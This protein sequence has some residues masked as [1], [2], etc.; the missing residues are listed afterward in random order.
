MPKKQ[1]NNA[2]MNGQGKTKETVDAYLGRGFRLWKRAGRELGIVPAQLHPAAFLVWLEKL[3]PS[4]KPSS[5]RL[6]LAA[7]K[8]LLNRFLASKKPNAGGR[9]KFE[10]AIHKADSMRAKDYS[11]EIKSKRWRGQTSSQKEKKIDMADMERLVSESRSM[12]G[13][14]IQPALDWMRVNILVGLRP[15][16]WKDVRLIG[17]GGKLVLVVRNAKNTNGRSHG[18]ERHIDLTHLDASEIQQI[19]EQIH[20]LGSYAKDDAS[21]S[22]FYNGVRKAIH[23]ITRKILPC[24]RKYPTLYSSRHQFSADAKAADMSKSEVA[25]LM[26]H[27]VETTAESHYGKKKHG[28][29]GFRVQPMREEVERVRVRS[30]MKPDSNAQMKR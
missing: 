6:Y 20:L 15:C 22:R 11:T 7:T 23:K 21:W 28:R 19:L 14:W 30:D 27:A 13:K 17:E 5:R 8:E 3:L 12:R 18:K 1:G 4:L 29:G 10:D 26:G 24:R 9:K 2:K 16:E 25:A